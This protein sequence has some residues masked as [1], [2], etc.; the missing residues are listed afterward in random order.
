MAQINN[1]LSQKCLSISDRQLL[2]HDVT[3]RGFN[4]MSNAG[5]ETKMKTKLVLNMIFEQAIEDDF[6]RK[7]PLRF[8]S[9]RI[10]GTS[11][12]PTEPYSV[13]Q[14]RK[15]QVLVNG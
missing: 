14:S 4:K 8:R 9:I 11:S 10:T 13:E 2:A 15:T 1:K 5:K 7:N 12:R 6:I 3:G